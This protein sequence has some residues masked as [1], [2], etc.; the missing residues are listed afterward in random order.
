[1]TNDEYN[2]V[3]SRAGASIHDYAIVFLKAGLR[4][5]ELIALTIDG[6]DHVPNRVYSGTLRRNHN[7]S[8]YMLCFLGSA[9]TLFM[10]RCTVADGSAED[11]AQLEALASIWRRRLRL[12]D[13]QLAKMIG[14]P[15]ASV[16][17]TFEHEDAERQLAQVLADLRRAHP[18]P[19]ADRSP[20]LSLM[21][22]Q[23]Y[24]MMP[25][26]VVLFLC[27]RDCSKSAH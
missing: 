26:R 1:L 15:S 6:I 19:V 14:N 13:I 23:R 9:E 4:I 16:Q 12:L 3:H 11:I 21:T 25:L 17:L 18:G 24:V 10:R 22:F 2:A 7:F 20:Y 8:V 5:S 27:C